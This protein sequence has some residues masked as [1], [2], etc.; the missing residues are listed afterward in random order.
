[1]PPQNADDMDHAAVFSLAIALASA[2]QTRDSHEYWQCVGSLHRRP[3]R[4]V[5]EG[6]AALCA[7]DS[8]IAR[9]VCADVLAQ[10]GE[11]DSNDGRPFAADTIPILRALLIDGHDQVVASAVHALSHHR[12]ADVPELR[13]LACHAS[14]DVRY[15]V[16]HALTGR[17]EPE[18]VALLLQLMTDVVDA[19]RDWATFAIGTHCD[20]DTRDIRGA[21]SARLADS[22]DETRG[23]AMVGLARRGDTSVISMVADALEG[24]DPGRLVFD[25]AEEILEHYPQDE[26]ISSALAKW[27]T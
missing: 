4:E 11:A 24:A 8:S 26:L 13:E 23:E 15:A 27:R 21:L 2:D 6:A 20:A 12:G 3:N 1:M 16:A 14:S 22:D 5:F 19:V 17:E 10:L 18:A 25:A 9:V 7:G